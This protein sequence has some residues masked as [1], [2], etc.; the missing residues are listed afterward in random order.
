MR[1]YLTFI[2]L[3]SGYLSSFDNLPQEHIVSYGDPSAKLKVTDYFSISCPSCRNLHQNDLKKII[4]LA[5]RGE[6]YFEMHPIP[7]DLTTVEV[8]VC[9]EYLNERE[10]KAFLE[11]MLEELTDSYELNQTILKRGMELLGKPLPD[12]GE[13]SFVESTR[14]FKDAYEFV[15]QEDHPVYIPAISIN[16]K[17]FPKQKPT[18]AFIQSC[19]HQSKEQSNHLA[20][21]R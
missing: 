15:C 10:K 14:S 13:K 2:L 20:I 19:L 18:F 21:G 17:F 8:M 6:I 7:A 4:G 3:L 11:I 12:L 5:N 9:L 16:G 1:S